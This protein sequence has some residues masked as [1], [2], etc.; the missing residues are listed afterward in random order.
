[1]GAAAMG[2]SGWQLPVDHWRWRNGSERREGEERDWGVL[3][4]KAERQG[5]VGLFYLFFFAFY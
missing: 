2:A 4:E 5:K 1:M 3:V